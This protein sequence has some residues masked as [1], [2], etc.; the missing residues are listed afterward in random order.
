MQL[1]R[2]YLSRLNASK[3]FRWKPIIWGWW[4]FASIAG[5]L[6]DPIWWIDRQSFLASVVHWQTIIALWLLIGCFCLVLLKYPE[7]EPCIFLT[8]I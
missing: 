2:N 7:E 1:S 6:R 3:V 4:E 5:K 8:A